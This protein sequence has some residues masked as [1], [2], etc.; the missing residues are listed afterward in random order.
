MKVVAAQKHNS[1]KRITTLNT[2]LDAGKQQVH[3]VSK[4]G[5]SDFFDTLPTKG[6]ISVES[7]GDFHLPGNLFAKGPTIVSL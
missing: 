7:Q 6:K 1:G 3:L 5:C 4:S 2:G